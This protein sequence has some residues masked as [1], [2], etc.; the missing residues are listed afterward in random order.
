MV[1]TVLICPSIPPYTPKKSPFYLGT[2]LNVY[3][4]YCRMVDGREAVVDL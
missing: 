1:S 4:L 2:L 3:K